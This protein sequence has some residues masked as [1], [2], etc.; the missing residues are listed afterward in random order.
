MSSLM[1]DDPS[2]ERQQQPITSIGVRHEAVILFYKYLDPASSQACKL[3]H[4]YPSHFLPL[5]E[6]F[7]K[8]LCIR[9]GCKG[10]ILLA[11]EGINGTLSAVSLTTLQEYQKA[12][13]A[14]DLLDYCGIPQKEGEAEEAITTT[15]QDQVNTEDKEKDNPFIYSGIDWKA[16]YLNTTQ[17][18]SSTS[19]DYHATEPFPN[20]KISIVKE[21]VSSGGVVSVEE[22]A[23]FGGRHLSPEEFHQK[24]VAQDSKKPVVLIDVRNTFEHAIGHFVNPNTQ[25]PAMNPEM[26]TFSTFD[27]KF[28]ET[29]A[30]SLR[31]STVLMYCT[32]GIRCEKAS[33]MLK[34]R[35]VNDVFQLNGGIHR[36]LETFGDAGYFK[37]RNFQFDQRVSLTPAEHYQQKHLLNYYGDANDNA[38]IPT[39]MLPKSN[40]AVVGKCIEC[41]A[42]FDEISGSRICTVCRDLVLV[43]CKCQK[44]MRE[45]HC[46][47]HVE[48]NCYFTFLEVFDQQQLQEQLKQLQALLNQRNEEYSKHVRKTLRKQIEKVRL[49]I[50]EIAE[51]PERVDR[52]AP[53][54]CRSCREPDT[55]CN[56]LCWGFWKTASS[57]VSRGQDADSNPHYI[58]KVT[59]PAILPIQPGDKVTP[60]PHWN[61]IRYGKATHP[62]TGRQLEGT[63]IEVKSWGSSASELDCVAVQWDD[64]DS[65]PRRRQ[66]Q[67][68]RW[69][70]KAVNGDRMYDLQPL[71]PWDLTHPIK[72]PG[73]Y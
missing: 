42:P 37:G 28:C 73:G 13:E 7:Q 70:A 63:V 50:E 67:I 8:D 33:V 36:Y 6:K 69:G 43:C 60:G 47:R 34:K 32:G 26:V 2:H 40:N 65:L 52:N 61:E 11:A 51:H 29:H 68:Y 62:T 44:R 5:M 10:R 19:S 53:R 20:L 12:M 3:L 18:S 48:W 54:R 30:D 31:D 57:T 16:S 9:L 55:M 17:S 21:L 66:V 58:S 39:T 35:G 4:Q 1:S 72:Q 38:T 64:P 23:Q 45:Y 14:F 49:R 59:S 41:D 27:A 25:Q 71:L 15:T 24:I 56:G 22:I 46:R